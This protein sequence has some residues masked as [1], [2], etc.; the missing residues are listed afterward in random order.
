MTKYRCEFT[1]NF[2]RRFTEVWSRIRSN[3]KC[4]ESTFRAIVWLRE[5]WSRFHSDS[6]LLTMS[7]SQFTERLSWVS[8]MMWV[9][10]IPTITV[11]NDPTNLV[12]LNTFWNTKLVK[13]HVSSV[14]ARVVIYIFIGFQVA[15]IGDIEVLSN[16]GTWP[17]TT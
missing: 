14:P 8:R 1:V 11:P 12:Q 7:R 6:L 9:T 17:S 2:G 4:M 15:V 13:K 16:Q 10:L 5:F 3:S